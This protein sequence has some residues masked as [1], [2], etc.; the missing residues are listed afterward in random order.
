MKNLKNKKILITGS[1]TGL[2]KHIALK[3]AKKGALILLLSNEEEELC[4]VRSKIEKDGVEA[5]LYVCDLRELDQIK[6]CVNTIL[7]DHGHIDVLVNNAGVWTENV[8]EE[9]K[10]ELRKEAFL[11]NVLG[12]I[13]M[14]EE[15]LPMFRKQKKGHIFN[16]I[17]DSALEQMNIKNWRAYGASKWGMRGYTKAIR[18]S[19]ADTKVKVSAFY[20]GGFES[21]LYERVGKKDAHKQPWMMNTSELAEI[22]VFALTRPEDICVE[23]VVVTKVN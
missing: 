9:K 10:P 21:M 13:H 2:G 6:T 5:K 1:S 4:S 12:H 17:S 3:L 11:V 22:V 18:E 15:L 7:K 8:L 16:V 20:P 23:S 19:L 14:T